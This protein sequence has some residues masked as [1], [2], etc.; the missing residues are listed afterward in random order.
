MR[1]IERPPGVLPVAV[2]A[3]AAAAGP[4]EAR[5]VARAA[6]GDGVAFETLY[7]RHVG[8]VYSV[9]LRLTGDR[10]LAEEHTQECFVRAWQNLGSF[11]AE[12]AF[13]TWTYRIA[14]NLALAGFRD[15]TRRGAKVVE[16]LGDE[17]LE[18]V[19]APA[20]APHEGIDLERAVASLPPGARTVFVLHDVEGWQHDEIAEQL[21]LAVGT[22]KAQLH[23]ARRLLRERLGS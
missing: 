17:L 19:A 6:A 8:R 18:S 21:G 23:R 14:T 7:R 16:G 4:D 5:L 12:A 9:C 11:R 20:A 22:C 1:R 10:T 3:P 15:R 13:G 2:D